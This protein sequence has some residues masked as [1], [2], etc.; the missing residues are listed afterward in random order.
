[1]KIGKKIN[2]NVSTYALRARSISLTRKNM[3]APS[4][5][6]L[7]RV[8]YFHASSHIKPQSVQ[9]RMQMKAGRKEHKNNG[10][11]HSESFFFLLH[12]T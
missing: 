4:E 11:R 5:L 2:T 1:M 10:S 7:Q 12:W 3:A 9:M 6:I 8:T